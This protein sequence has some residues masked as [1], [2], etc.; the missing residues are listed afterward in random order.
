LGAYGQE[1]VEKCLSIL[2]SELVR[3]MQ[4]AGTTSLASIDKDSIWIN[5]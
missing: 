5:D 1:G 3:T 4:F 2:N